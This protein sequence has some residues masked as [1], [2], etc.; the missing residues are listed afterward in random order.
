MQVRP[1]SGVR[2]KMLGDGGGSIGKGLQPNPP[3]ARVRHWCPHPG[4]QPAELR[5]RSPSRVLS[6]AAVPPRGRVRTFRPVRRASPALLCVV[7]ATRFSP[8]GRRGFDSRRWLEGDAASPAPARRTRRLK[9]GE[10]ASRQMHM[11]C[12]KQHMVVWGSMESPSPRQGEDREF[13][14]RLDRME[15]DR[16]LLN[17]EAR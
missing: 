9:I 16:R 2:V 13:E 5:V 17:W 14:S 11:V 7:G 15:V 4:S 6:A 3:H 8:C 12:W 1:L 10:V